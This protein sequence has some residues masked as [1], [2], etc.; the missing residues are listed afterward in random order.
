MGK[1]RIRDSLIRKIM[2][3]AVHEMVAKHANRPD[4]SHFLRSE[5]VEYRTQAEKTAEEYNW[6]EEDKKH[7]FEKSLKMMKEKLSLK[8]ADVIFSEQEAIKKLKEIIEETM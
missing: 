4:A 6:N 2:N 1:N 8:Y 7:V 5:I 3:I